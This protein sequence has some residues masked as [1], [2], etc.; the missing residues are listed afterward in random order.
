MAKGLTM[1]Q[2]DQALG[3]ASDVLSEVPSS[4]F[5]WLWLDGGPRNK[6]RVREV[7]AQ[8]AYF[9]GFSGP[10][11]SGESEIATGGAAFAKLTLVVDPSPGFSTIKALMKEEISFGSK[12]YFN[13]PSFRNS[14]YVYAAGLA[15]LEVRMPSWSV[16][17]PWKIVSAKRVGGHAYINEEFVPPPPVKM[18]PPPETIFNGKRQFEKKFKSLSPKKSGKSEEELFIEFSPGELTVGLADPSGVA[19]TNLRCRVSGHPDVRGG[20][21]LPL[22]LQTDEGVVRVTPTLI[23]RSSREQQVLFDE[24]EPQRFVKVRSKQIGCSP[25]VARRLERGKVRQ[26]RD[27]R[28]QFSSFT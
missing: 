2:V 16:N 8:Q 23:V 10:S 20:A 11:G 25:T 17:P 6:T 21:I 15:F 1:L 26:R 14:P 4:I 18:A 3:V 28:I 5:A 22:T 7:S 27:M 9:T 19:L 13:A 12:Y 24:Q